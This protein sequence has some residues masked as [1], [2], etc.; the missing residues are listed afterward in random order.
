MGKYIQFYYCCRRHRRPA[1]LSI[2]SPHQR[3]LPAI[4]WLEGFRPGRHSMYQ[5]V[6]V[7]MLCGR[8]SIPAWTY[9]MLCPPYAE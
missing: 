9:W 5:R 8:T 1:L 2:G 7:A 3:D 6:M 4:N